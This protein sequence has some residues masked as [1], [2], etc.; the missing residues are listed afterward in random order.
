MWWGKRGVKD[1]S[2]VISL[3]NL[4]DSIVINRD[5]EPLGSNRVSECWFA[6]AGKLTKNG[7]YFICNY[8]LSDDT[9][10]C[11]PVHIYWDRVVCTEKSSVSINSL[12]FNLYSGKII[13]TKAE[14]NRVSISLFN[15]YSSLKFVILFLLRCHSKFKLV[16][17]W[18]WPA[19]LNWRSLM[20]V[21][22]NSRNLSL[23]STD[24]P[25]NLHSHSIFYTSPTYSSQGQ[26][27][28]K[29]TPIF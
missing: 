16:A 13:D 19:D 15:F 29:Q 17:T 27:I 21:K 20:E 6:W 28:L 18:A 9:Q 12:Y 5:R 7:M 22:T 14:S 2:Q 4:L 24:V 25:G 1:E 10:S 26:S 11:I 3:K 23:I 8:I